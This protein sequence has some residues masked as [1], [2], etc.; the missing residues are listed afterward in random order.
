MQ[1][2]RST[3]EDKESLQLYSFPAISILVTRLK[4]D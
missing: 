2:S 1:K 3:N 4:V